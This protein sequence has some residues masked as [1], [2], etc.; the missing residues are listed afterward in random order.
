MTSDA[1]AAEFAQT[2]PGPGAHD[3]REGHSHWLGIYRA[4]VTARCIDRHQAEFVRRGE[5][6][7][8]IPG[9]GHE[10][11]A[12]LGPHLNDEDWI[13][14]HYRDKALLVHRGVAAEAFLSASLCRSTA[15]GAG[16]QLPDIICSRRHRVL[17]TP[18]P[19]GNHALHAV[20]VAAA[21]VELRP[22][23]DFIVVC[24]AGDGTSQQGEYLEA[25]CEAIRRQLPV[26]FVI[27]DNGFAIST[28]TAG[29]TLVSTPAGPSREFLGTPITHLDGSDVAGACRDFRTIV[30]GIRRS[31]RPAI[32][33]LHVDRLTSH[34]NADDH[35]LYRDDDERARMR[36]RDPI[37]RFET[38]LAARAVSAAEQVSIRTSVEAEVAAAASRALDAADPVPTFTAKAPLPPALSSRDSETPLAADDGPETTLEAIR[39][40]L[41]SR[42]RRDSRVCLLG[43]DIEDP[44]GDVFGVTRG[45][46]TEFPGRVTNAPLSESTIVGTAIGRAIVGQRPIAFIQFADFLPLAF[47]QIANELATMYWRTAGEFAC[48]VV[49]MAPCGGYKPGMGPFH[50]QTFD[51]T[52]VH[53]PGLDV[54]MPTSAADVC[55]LL[56]SV[57]DSAR[58]TLFLYP[59][60][61]LNI[62]R[63]TRSKKCFDAARHRVP[64][65]VA[66]RLQSGNDVTMVAWGNTVRLVSRVAET[67]NEWGYSTDVLDL[68]SLSP[69][70]ES[71][72]IESAERTGRLLIVHEDNVSCGLGGEIA[73][74]V[75]ESAARP[76]RVLRIA[77]PDAPIPCHY[78][79]QLA[80]LPGFRSTLSGAAQLL[81][82]E[83][84]WDEPR[85]GC[86]DGSFVVQANGSGPADETVTVVQL[87]VKPGDRIAAG[88]VVATLE[89]SKCAVEVSAALGG[90]V[91]AVVVKAG[92]DVLVGRPLLV[93]RTEE[94]LRRLPRT[95]ER[96]ALP[97]LVKR[98]HEPGT[99]NAPEPRP[100]RERTVGIVTVRSATGARVVEHHELLCHHPGRTVEEVQRLTGIDSR[101]WLGA[102][103]DVLS[104][105]V[106]AARRA[107]DDAALDPADLD[108][109]ICS[110]VTPTQMTPSMAC[111]VMARLGGTSRAATYD[112]TAAC[113]GYLYALGIAHD[114]LQSS[115]GRV[116]VLTADAL[117][118]KTDVRDFD[119]AFL[120]GDAATATVLESGRRRA[121]GLSLH[122]PIL[123]SKPELGDALL[124]PASAESGFVKMRGGRVFTEAVRE[125]A[126]ILER[127]CAASRI[128]TSDLDLIVP[129]QA[130]GRI[131]DVI[132]ARV[133]R[134][135][136]RHLRTVGN[137]SSSSIPL[138]LEAQ[139][140]HGLRA[141]RIG[142]CSFGGGFTS[143]AAVIEVETTDKPF[144]AFEVQS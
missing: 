90:V 29:M 66:R 16:R 13:A 55:G 5:A 89:T 67:L 33:A 10:T 105:A 15:P 43:Q 78:E 14:A 113:S 100:A 23:S 102:G 57:L 52:A 82:V 48:P 75:A 124:V 49:L 18:V 36:D 2:C 28:R 109:V 56:N 138:A 134:P 27:E 46:S 26:L 59:K 41:R 108:L 123:S 117:S 74:R 136:A 71:Q 30:A 111:Q 112:V 9:E 35:R 79:S 88:D 92:D 119:T 133:G 137:T 115:P 86:E 97:R 142:L 17:S 85:T 44:K 122:R 32:V 12:A 58:P 53:V 22:A 83:I 144:P 84:A 37:A 128:A 3:D 31:R 61:A 50:A 7:F 24:T 69:W 130:N 40:V 8:H 116:L 72:V 64:I 94:T 99:T 70:D 42:L 4:M 76:P 127:A 91:T 21:E 19:V 95:E 34:T 20:G 139:I 25:L 1:C 126:A 107:L 54:V 121:S 114:F 6:F 132:E 39:G 93:I 135:V 60:A 73:A 87:L 11:I 101:R 110:T 38:A 106:A 77:R 81:D 125:M 63:R 62:V 131:L 141:N 65:G 98:R 45:L 96:I 118:T 140:A 120:F 129:H 47:N 51:G 103:E 80:V 68:R 143:G 104:L